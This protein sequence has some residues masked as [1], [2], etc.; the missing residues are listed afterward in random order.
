MI[1][2][3]RLFRSELVNFWVFGDTINIFLLLVSKSIPSQKN[4]V[5][6]NVLIL[7]F[8]GQ[9]YILSGEGHPPLVRWPGQP[10]SLFSLSVFAGIL[11][12]CWCINTHLEL[13]FLFVNWPF[14]HYVMSPLPLLNS[15]FL[16]VTY[17]LLS[18]FVEDT[19]FH[20][21]TV[22]LSV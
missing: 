14:D 7:L 19:A 4:S 13:L 21:F 11:Q 15:L 8:L 20:L 3:F 16:M 5:P 22:N 17:L 18:V 2:C 6:L 10:I 9:K 12:F 1:I